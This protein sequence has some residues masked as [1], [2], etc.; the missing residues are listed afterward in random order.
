MIGRPEESTVAELG[1][2]SFVEEL[3][4][5]GPF[6]GEAALRAPEFSDFSTFFRSFGVAISRNVYSFRMKYCKSSVSSR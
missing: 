3:V 5:F 4:R 6:N 2:F 1:Q